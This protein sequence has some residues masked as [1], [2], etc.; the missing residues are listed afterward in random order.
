MTIVRI[1]NQKQAF[2]KLCMIGRNWDSEVE[3][4]DFL[5]KIS[6]VITSFVS[7]PQ[8]KEIQEEF[9]EYSIFFSGQYPSGIRSGLV[10]Y[11]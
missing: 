10:L 8:L 11:H 3:I 2:D 6:L 1:M 5:G 7:S 9:G 4:E